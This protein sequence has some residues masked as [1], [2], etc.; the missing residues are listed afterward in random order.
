M[1]GLAGARTGEAGDA[2]ESV[3]EPYPSKLA[4]IATATGLGRVTTEEKGNNDA[5]ER[6]L[7][8]PQAQTYRGKD[9]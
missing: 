1:E 3:S 5:D 4:S 8:T 2:A 9:V 6:Q 7:Y